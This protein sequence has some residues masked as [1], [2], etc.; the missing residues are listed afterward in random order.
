MHLDYTNTSN[1]LT[2]GGTI[3]GTRRDKPN[4]MLMGGRRSWT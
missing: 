1:V 3:L 4:K 2:V